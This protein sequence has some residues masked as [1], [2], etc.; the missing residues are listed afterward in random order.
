MTSNKGQKNVV[1]A[2]TQFKGSSPAGRVS[3][4]QVVPSVSVLS[5]ESLP[6]YQRLWVEGALQRWG[7]GGK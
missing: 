3:W 2:V 5:V 6:L 1:L 7:E 4:P